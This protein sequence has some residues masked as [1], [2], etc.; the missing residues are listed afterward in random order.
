MI[1]NPRIFKGY[2]L[3]VVLRRAEDGTND[4]SI[5]NRKD[6][7]AICIAK[8]PRYASDYDWQHNADLICRAVKAMKAEPKGET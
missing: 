3:E 5:V 8:A 2:K 1:E 6:G 7:Y 4:G